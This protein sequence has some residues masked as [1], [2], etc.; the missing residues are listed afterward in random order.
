MRF[1]EIPDIPGVKRML[2]EAVKSNHSAHAQLFVGM[3][4]AL[5]LPLAL[6]YATYLHCQNRGDDARL[7]MSVCCLTIESECTPAAPGKARRA[8]PGCLT[9]E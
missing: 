1:E 4:G 7:R 2:I 3:E 9:I 6:A 5:N 8:K